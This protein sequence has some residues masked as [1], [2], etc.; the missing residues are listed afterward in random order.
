MSVGRQAANVRGAQPSLP[1]TRMREGGIH[2][3]CKFIHDTPSA[4]NGSPFPLINAALSAASDRA[5]SIPPLC[6]S[7]RRDVLRDP[8]A[9]QRERQSAQYGSNQKPAALR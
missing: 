8:R 3:S 6:S 2:F 4:D 7:S 5:L 9:P 1:C